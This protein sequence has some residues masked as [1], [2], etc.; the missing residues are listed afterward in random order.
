MEHA[1]EKI[2]M[3]SSRPID[4]AFCNVTT[5]HVSFSAGCSPIAGFIVEVVLC[6]WSSCTI[7]DALETKDIMIM[8]L[9]APAHENVTF[10]NYW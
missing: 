3:P 9:E 8:L 5:A 6:I 1:L 2:V 4:E 10:T 7:L